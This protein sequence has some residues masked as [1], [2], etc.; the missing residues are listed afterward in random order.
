MKKMLFTLTVLASAFCAMTFTACGDKAPEAAS[1]NKPA[2][3]AAN[4][5][6][7]ATD[8]AAD[9]A[10]DATDAAADAAKDAADAAK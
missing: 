10:K 5:A 7:D 1:E 9:A 6:K 8:G 2:A 4:A 3:D